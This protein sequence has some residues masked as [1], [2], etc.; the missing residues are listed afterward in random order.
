MKTIILNTL[1]IF[2]LLCAMAGSYKTGYN[3]AVKK[4]K[5]MLAQIQKEKERIIKIQD[6]TEQ[7]Q[8]KVLE[9]QNLI[10][11]QLEIKKGEKKQ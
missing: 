8:K 2:S 4:T 9:I 5:C 11:K 10:R 3:R 1:I 6:I 7:E